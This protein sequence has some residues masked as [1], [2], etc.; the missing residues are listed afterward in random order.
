MGVKFLRFWMD[1]K[2][3]IFQKLPVAH[4]EIYEVCS[5]LQH[6]MKNGTAFS[7]STYPVCIFIQLKDI[8]S[9]QLVLV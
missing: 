8:T 2:V 1:K 5:W 4:F 7:R 3:S 6:H 9:R